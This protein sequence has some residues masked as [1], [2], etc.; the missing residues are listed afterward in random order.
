[1]TVEVTVN[2]ADHAAYF[3]GLESSFQSG[4][5]QVAYR[6]Y[7]ERRLAGRAPDRLGLYADSVLVAGVGVSYRELSLPHGPRC[8]VAILTG[9]AQQLARS[10]DCVALLGFVTIDNASATVLRRAGAVSYP[11]FYLQADAEMNLELPDELWP[12]AVAPPPAT[13]SVDGASITFVYDGDGWRSQFLERPNPTWP[14]RAG[15]HVAVVETTAD[16]DRLQWF[17][18]ADATALIAL[19]SIARWALGRGQRFFYFTTSRVLA[20]QA[21]SRGFRVFDGAIMTFDLRGS[22]GMWHDEIWSRG[23]WRVQNGD[24]L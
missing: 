8:T 11:T 20:E 14:V 24:R 10:K 9:A 4:W 13:Q 2:S 7:F 6:W 16:T 19:C 18:G 5:T 3:A 15:T 21:A 17:D 22:D 1:M 23:P 12:V